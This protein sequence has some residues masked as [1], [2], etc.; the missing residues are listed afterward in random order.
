M[1][2][3]EFAASLALRNQVK[4]KLLGRLSIT[5]PLLCNSCWDRQDVIKDMLQIVKYDKELISESIHD[6]IALIQQQVLK[7]LPGP[8]K[9]TPGWVNKHKRNM[10]VRVP[11]YNGCDECY[12]HSE[13]L[14]THIFW[15]CA[16][17]V[18]LKPFK[19]LTCFNNVKQYENT[20]YSAD[21]R[22]RP[23]AAVTAVTTPDFLE[24]NYIPCLITWKK[25]EVALS[26]TSSNVNKEWNACLQ[27]E[28]KSRKSTN[29]FLLT[30][31]DSSTSQNWAK[32]LVL[33][34]NFNTPK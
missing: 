26:N 14:Y 11:W 32:S 22:R 7:G 13:A 25:F 21:A 3:H 17:Q 1:D 20:L 28:R 5:A 10:S 31:N 27:C 29:L 4:T 18:Q 33:I 16:R 12:L 30:V 2:S 34:E 9:K 8:W 23:M 6:W 24:A 15:G 19:T